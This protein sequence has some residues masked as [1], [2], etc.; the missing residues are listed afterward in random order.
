MRPLTPVAALPVAR[1]RRTAT[2]ATPCFILP[3]LLL[4]LVTLGPAC[5]EEIAVELPQGGQA[6]ARFHAGSPSRPA[7]LVL[8]GFLTSHHFN[9]VASMVELLA[10]E[11]F[12]VLAPNLTLGISKRRSGLP[13]DAIHTQGMEEDLAEIDFWVRWL[14]NRGH[15]EIVLVGH[16]MGSLQLV[17]Y[18]AHRHPAAVRLLVATSLTYFANPRVTPAE[19]IRRE[20]ARAE[21]LSARGDESPRRFSLSFCQGN[22][23]STPSAY[24][25]YLRWDG[26]R[27]LAAL[28]EIPIPRVVIMGG[29]DD[30]F[31]ADWRRRL[32]ASGARIIVIPGASHFFDDQFEFDLHDRLLEAVATLP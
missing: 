21:A 6:L 11:G 15:R 9:T 12:T 3:F 22:Y 10:E 7:I 18:L 24:L 28:Q 29:A 13:C 19:V 31:E 2:P 1:F 14:E 25:S 32:E 16:S 27:L 30:R 8:H 26:D 17:A 20:R 4:A 5:A 23:V